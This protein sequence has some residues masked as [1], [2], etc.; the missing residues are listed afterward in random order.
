MLWWAVTLVNKGITLGALNRSEEEIA[1]YDDVIARFE[2]TK[3]AALKM[4]VARALFNKGVALASR[5]GARMRSP[6]MTMWSRAL[7]RRRMPC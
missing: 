2:M 1:V 4:Q 3:D 7:G 6:S 5:T